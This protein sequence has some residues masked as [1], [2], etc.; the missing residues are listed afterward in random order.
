MSRA[1]IITGA[2][3]SQGGAV[4]DALVAQKA[5]FLLLA[6]TRN[7][8]SPSAT[9]LASKSKNIKL[10]KGDLNDVPSVFANAKEAAGSV[11][12]WG[13]Y[14]VQQAIGAD[15]SV[16]KEEV[17]GKAIV[18]E[19]IKNDIKY[20]VYSSVDRGGDK[21]SWN[22]PTEV[23]H[24]ASKHRVELHLR[25]ATA[26]GKS[27]MGWTI[28]RPVAFME[29]FQVGM[30][31][32][33]FL[34]AMRDT[35]G[36]KPLQFVAVKDIG[37]AAAQAFQNPEAWNHKATGLASEEVTYAELSQIWQRAI[38]SPAPGSFWIL[39]WILKRA[40]KELGIMINWFGKVG[41]GVDIESNK[42]FNP[43]PVTLESWLRQSGWNKGN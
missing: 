40:V 20:L 22:D 16:E 8:Q 15:A 23:P 5:D 25:D 6:V 19:A 11:P 4:I 37:V 17:Q 32:K 12:I 39:G 2:T 9:K 35:L 10:V 28:L 3:G 31:T 13:F 1:I 18:D 30:G 14:S 7:T 26:N 29:N 38:G 41:Y 34:A 27:S 21:Q 33:V 42:K 43:T 36:D 24:F